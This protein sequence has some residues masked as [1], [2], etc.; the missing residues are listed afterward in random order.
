M[1]FAVSGSHGTGKTTLITEVARVL[2]HRTSVHI[3]R[4]IPETIISQV[5]D[6]QFFQR[7]RNSLVRQLLICLKQVVVENRERAKASVIL[8]DRTLIDHLAY[9]ALLFPAFTESIEFDLLFRM[10][11]ESL[12]EYNAIFKLPIEF[13]IP[14]DGI[15]EAD[16][17]FQL[18]I[19]GLIEQFYM[20]AGVK[21]IIVSGHLQARSTAV[22]HVIEKYL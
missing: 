20:K 11:A 5:N 12:R 10:T 9:T 2:A 6:S 21:P 14:A 18:A 7:S 19:D 17:E 16:I 3:C 15:R 1:K 22:V 8:V 13:G 4:E